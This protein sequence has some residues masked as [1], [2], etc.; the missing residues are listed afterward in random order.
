VECTVRRFFSSHILIQCAWAATRTKGTYLHA[1]IP[2]PSLTPWRQKSYWSHRRFHPHRRLQQ[3]GSNPRLSFAWDLRADRYGAFVTSKKNAKV[4]HDWF[5]TADVTDDEIQSLG[6][7]RGTNLSRTVNGVKGQLSN[8]EVH[9]VRPVRRVGP[10]GQQIME[11]VVEIT[12][13]WIPDGQNQIKYRGGSTLIIDLDTRRIRY[14]VRKRVANADRIGSQQGFQLAGAGYSLRENYFDQT[15]PGSE[16]F[17]ML[18][19]GV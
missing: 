5:L 6:F 11:L 16:P 18:H 15:A 19:R 7:F 4:M 3:L 14:C 1:S 17:A 2:A 9:S 10:D 8:F 12:Q 13:S